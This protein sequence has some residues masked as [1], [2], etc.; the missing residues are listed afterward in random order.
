M[1]VLARFFMYFLSFYLPPHA[2]YTFH[3]LLCWT[4]FNLFYCIV[5]DVYTSPCLL[6]IELI[7]VSL[8]NIL[9]P[10]RAHT[11]P[12]PIFH[13]LQRHMRHHLRIFL[14]LMR[15]RHRFTFSA[16]PVWMVFELPFLYCVTLLLLLLIFTIID[17]TN[18]RSLSWWYTLLYLCLRI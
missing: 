15:L 16:G 2:V 7:A 3:S 8:V 12:F 13:R 11:C 18:N 6:Q 9:R 1:H 14:S 10:D 4:W 5:S 17:H